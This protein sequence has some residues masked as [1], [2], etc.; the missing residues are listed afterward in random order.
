[1]NRRKFISGL[2]LIG[3]GILLPWKR[4]ERITATEIM[5]WEQE[6]D[7][8]KLLEYWW[9][10]GDAVYCAKTIDGSLV[11][12]K[13]TPYKELPFVIVNTLPVK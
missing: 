1:M 3:L 12:Y 10:R 11:Y 6:R 8:V 7:S 4:G 2:G 5:R 9:E 13:K